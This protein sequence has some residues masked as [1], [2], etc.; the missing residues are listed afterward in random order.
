M[1]VIYH[2]LKRNLYELM[3]FVGIDLDSD[4]IPETFVVELAVF[5]TDIVHIMKPRVSR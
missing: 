4:L 2:V 5:G 3:K 1:I